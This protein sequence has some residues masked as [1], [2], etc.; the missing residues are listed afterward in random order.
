MSNYDDII[1]LERPKLKHER[2]SSMN[3]A[4]QFSPFSALTGYEESI[5]ETS[6]LT[7]EKL[8][9]SA[10]ELERVQKNISILLERLDEKPMVRISYFIKDKLKQG[11]SYVTKELNIKKVDLYEKCLI[12]IDKEKIYFDDILNVEIL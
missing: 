4:A 8:E 10:D 1:N 3:R 7:T 9:L 5:I 12:S 11:G 2:M 6:R